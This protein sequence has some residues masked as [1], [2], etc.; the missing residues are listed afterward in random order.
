MKNAFLLALVSVLLLSCVKIVVNINFPETEAK[1]AISA[2]EN[3]LLRSSEETQDLLEAVPEE[4]GS[5][6]PSEQSR[7]MNGNIFGSVVYAAEINSADIL[8][9]IKSRPEVISAYNNRS[10]RLSKVKALLDEGKAGENSK[11]KL[12][13][14]LPGSF[15]QSDLSV[16]N[17]ENR[18]RDTIIMALYLTILE[19]NGA[20]DNAQAKNDFY[21]KAE[22][23]FAGAL[24]ENASPGWWIQ[25][26]NGKW[27]KK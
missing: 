24:H 15:S 13:E 18:D 19:I 5:D 6:D 26:S 4:T 12:E 25:L 17:D 7:N 16:V 8:N 27:K 23:S 21:P 22:S 9:R 14:R 3:E 2:L 20:E 11:G 1:E 10:M